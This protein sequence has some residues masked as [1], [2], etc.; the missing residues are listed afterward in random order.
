MPRTGEKDNIQLFVF[1]LKQIV[2]LKFPLLQLQQVNSSTNSLWAAQFTFKP[3][4][5][6]MSCQEFLVSIVFMATVF[7]M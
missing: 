4:R 3:T 6:K 1:D 2:V 7:I 5:P